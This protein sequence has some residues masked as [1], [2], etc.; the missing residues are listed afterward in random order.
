MIL[1]NSLAYHKRHPELVRHDVVED[2]IDR[3]GRVVENTWHIGHQNIDELHPRA[4]RRDVIIFVGAVY[5]DQTLYMERQPAD[6]KRYDNRD[7]NNSRVLFLFPCDWMSRH[8]LALNN[9]WF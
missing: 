9:S 5:R 4:V 2:R 8:R 6:E 1:P 7:C 3:R